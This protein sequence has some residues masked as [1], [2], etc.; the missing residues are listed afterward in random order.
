MNSTS[1]SSPSPSSSSTSSSESPSSVHAGTGGQAAHRSGVPVAP[2][3][4]VLAG[5]AAAAYGARRVIRG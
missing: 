3:P 2:L 4:L 1:T 5:L